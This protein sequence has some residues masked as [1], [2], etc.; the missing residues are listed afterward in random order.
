MSFVFYDT[1]TTG[2]STAFDQI[3]QFAAIKTDYELK[4]LDRFEMRCRLLPYVVPSPGAI[5]VNG[6]SIEQL[7]DP[8]L[9]SHYQMV[10]TIKSRLTAWS[11]AIFIGHNSIGFDE[12][13][14]RQ[15]FYKTL[16]PPYL[17]NTNG[18]CRSCSL[19]MIQ[20]VARFAPEALVIP[21]DDYG[22]P[23]FKLDRLAPANGFEHRTAHD[24][25]ADV[26]ATIH[27]CRLIADRAPAH[28][29]NLI[30]FAQKAAVTEFAL[31]ESVFALTDFY[32]GTPYSWMVTAIGVNPENKSE[33]LVFDLS[34]DPDNL[35]VMPEDELVARLAENPKP[36]RGMRCN[37]GPIVFAYEDAPDDMR[38]AAPALD[39]LSRRVARLKNDPGLSERLIAAFIQARGARQPSVHVEEQ[40]YDGFASNEDN[41]L[42]D[43]FH[44]REWAERASLIEQL[45]DGRLRSL[46]QRL[47][48]VEA[49]HVMAEAAQ[50]DY[51]AAIARR[52][53]AEDGTVPWLT[54]PKAIAETDDFL[55]I[56]DPAESALLMELRHYLRDR[57]L[58]AAALRAESL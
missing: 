32:G 47:I 42:L 16:H 4:E 56:A 24:A 17:T 52:L 38:S 14:L 48:Y 6:V 2:T 34:H 9:P 44:E 19:R 46:G 1:E 49:P 35:A 57:A 21:M 7:T 25:M 36:V 30:R 58:E 18:N 50:Q 41:A 45:A 11:P 28:W 10:R 37:A 22:R 20:A 40:I 39:E 5:R 31:D 53:M 29:S 13:L 12:H 26:E 3:L 33:M 27:M 15:A 51:A 43:R 54:F 23:L 55:A 8:A